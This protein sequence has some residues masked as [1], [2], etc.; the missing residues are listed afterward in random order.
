LLLLVAL[1]FLVYAE[2]TYTILFVEAYAL[3]AAGFV[4]FAFHSSGVGPY[5]AAGLLTGTVFLAVGIHARLLE[6]GR[7]G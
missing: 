1:V 5:V 3:L 4:M 2:I 7:R 6:R